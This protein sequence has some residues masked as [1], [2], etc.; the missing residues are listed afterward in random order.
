MQAHNQMSI[1]HINKYGL[2]MYDIVITHNIV[3]ILDLWHAGSILY[4][5]I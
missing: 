5:Y 1:Y 4:L 3:S 2:K